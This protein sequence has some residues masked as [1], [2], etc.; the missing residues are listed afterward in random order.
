M[1]AI[2]FLTKASNVLIVVFTTVLASSGNAASLSQS[3]VLVSYLQPNYYTTSGSSGTL[4]EFTQNGTLIQGFNIPIATGSSDF[5]FL[6]GVAV[7]SDARV[8]IFNGTFRPSI[9]LLE[10]TTS[11]VTSMTAPHWGV[12]GDISSG[13]VVPY[14]T[15]IFATNHYPVAASYG[16]GGLI[17]LDR[18]GELPI[19]FGDPLGY[20]DATLGLDG[21]LYG[22]SFQSNLDI[23]NPANR[24]LVGTVV[25]PSAPVAIAVS[26]D[27][28]IFAA[29][30]DGTVSQIS[31]GGISVGP[32]ISTGESFID[33]DLNSAGD[34]VLGTRSGKVVMTSEGLT[35]WSSFATQPASWAEVP[36]HVAFSSGIS[37]VPDLPPSLSFI[38]GLLLLFSYR[39][40]NAARPL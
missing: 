21:F 16:V 6:R 7:A 18:S 1:S 36:V 40:R 8:L 15:N 32:S 31:R 27:G 26:A 35:G 10:P 25:I 3:S 2:H 12:I 17:Q 5:N 37:P 22:L 30:R 19:Y 28:K 13:A 24:E 11:V 20:R 38:M 34:I 33:I 9:S 39:R 29:Q 14:G 4:N 23:Y